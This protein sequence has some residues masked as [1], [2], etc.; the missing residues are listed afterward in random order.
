MKIDFC[1]ENQIEA[2]YD[3]LDRCVYCG[4]DKKTLDT[5]PNWSRH[6][7]LE[8]EEEKGGKKENAN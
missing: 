3:E 7:L 6:Q 8:T 2:Q 5:Y 4:L 1:V